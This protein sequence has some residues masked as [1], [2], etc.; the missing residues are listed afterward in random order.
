MIVQIDN[1]NAKIALS[2]HVLKNNCPDRINYAANNGRNMCEI[3]AVI[4]SGHIAKDA[5]KLDV[6]G[7]SGHKSGQMIKK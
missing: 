1:T 7:V 2:G 4:K 6:N 5:D 3:D